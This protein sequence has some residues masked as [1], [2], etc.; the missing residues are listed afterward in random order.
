MLS[1]LCPASLT[2]TGGLAIAIRDWAGAVLIISHNEVSLLGRGLV[3]DAQVL[4]RNSLAH[5]VKRLHPFAAL[6]IV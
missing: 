2:S 5:Y 1:G 3:V 4:F 6:Q